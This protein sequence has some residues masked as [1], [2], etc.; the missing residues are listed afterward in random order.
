MYRIITYYY[1]DEAKIAGLYAQSKKLWN[2]HVC[3]TRSAIISLLTGSADVDAI[4]ARL[5]KNQDE[6]GQL[7]YPYYSTEEAEAFTGVLKE[8]ITLAIAL[9]NAVK[10]GED[11]TAPTKAWYDNGEAM[12]TWMENENPHYWSRVVTQPLWN[13]HLKYTSDE[14]NARLKEDWSGDLDA[15]DMNRSCMQKWAELY[16]TG[17]VYNNMDMFAVKKQR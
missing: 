5:M 6:I 17:I 12:L 4:S 9:V 16:A 7:L 11:T 8:H 3:Y 10:A 13:D 14:V 2:E 15:F 1:E